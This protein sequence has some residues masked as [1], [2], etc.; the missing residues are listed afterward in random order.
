MVVVLVSFCVWT[1]IA[2]HAEN[3]DETEEEEQD[4]KPAGEIWKCKVKGDPAGTYYYDE[5][6]FD[7]CE[8]LEVD[9]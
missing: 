3:D 8:L 9:H 6:V 1:V 2:I 4:T 5:P 7:S